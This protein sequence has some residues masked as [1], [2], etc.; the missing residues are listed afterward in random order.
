M[1]LDW[2][3]SLIYVEKNL[4]QP[5]RTPANLHLITFQFHRICLIDRKMIFNSSFEKAWKPQN[6]LVESCVPLRTFRLSIGNHMR[7]AFTH[8]SDAQET[9]AVQTTTDRY[10]ERWRYTII[11]LSHFSAVRR[12]FSNRVTLNHIAMIGFGEAGSRRSATT[13]YLWQAPETQWADESSSSTLFRC[14]RGLLFQPA[15]RPSL[16]WK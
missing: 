15:A 3:L 16:M 11:S 9:T 7:Y 10:G 1:K 12:K 8:S 2:L 14:I 4:E 6:D 13:A 5:F